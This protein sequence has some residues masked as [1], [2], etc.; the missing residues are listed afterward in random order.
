MRRIRCL[1]RWGGLSALS[2]YSCS[3]FEFFFLEETAGVVMI[4]R[5]FIIQY[6]ALYIQMIMVLID[7]LSQNRYPCIWTHVRLRHIPNEVVVDM[8]GR[9]SGGRLQP[10]LHSVIV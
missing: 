9:S 1:Y 3:C 7:L 5:C 8:L 4:L 10:Q 2:L 6:L